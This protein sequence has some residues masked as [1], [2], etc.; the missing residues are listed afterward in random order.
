MNAWL[1]LLAKPP[2]A[3]PAAPPKTPPAKPAPRRPRPPEEEEEEDPKVDPR[4]PKELAVPKPELEPKLELEPNPELELP[5]LEP[6]LELPKPPEPLWSWAIVDH[7]DYWIQEVKERS[8]HHLEP[9]EY[10]ITVILL[11]LHIIIN[12]LIIITLSQR[13]WQGLQ[14]LLLQ[15]LQPQHLPA[16]HP[17]CLNH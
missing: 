3:P 10:I 4:F 14:L 12:L 9:K 2:P 13:S 11:L 16:R 15:D 5:S 6:E 17:P 1:I 8:D 7:D